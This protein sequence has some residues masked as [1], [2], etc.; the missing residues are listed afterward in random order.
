MRIAVLANK[1]LKE[2]FVF[3]KIPPNVDLIFADSHEALLHTKKADA[4]FDLEFEM[5]DKRIRELST[6]LPSLVFINSVI[7]TL[8]DINQ[9]FIRINGWPTLLK[10]NICEIAAGPG[11]KETAVRF[12]DELNWDYQLVGDTPGMVSPRIIAMIINE[13]YYTY[14][15][16]VSSKN[17]IDIAMKL[18]TNYPY[19]PFEW[20][21]MI[22]LKNIYNLLSRL[23][24]TDSS[25]TISKSME[26]EVNY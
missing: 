19:G 13:A 10:R 2:E 25:Y 15:E 5:D 7:D 6:L 4:Y 11:Q 26:I 14:E 24:N 8:G 20:S 22:G 3:K 12:F 16:K 21:E 9:P 23:K 1:E 17:E 18:G